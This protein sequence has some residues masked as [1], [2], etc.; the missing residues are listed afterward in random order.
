MW[1]VVSLIFLAVGMQ[2]LLQGQFPDPDD[3][4][5][6]VQVRDLLAG[7]GWF[8]LHQYRI[9]PPDGTLMHWSRLVDIPLALVILAL[10]PFVGAPAAETAAL[11]IVPLVTLGAILFV[12]GRL[13]WRL[14]DVD[15]AGISCL[16]MALFAPIVF[17][18]QPM[19]IDHHGWQIFTV[20]L[21]LWACS[22]RS[23]WKG[24]A[25]AGLAMAVGATISLEILPMVAA[26]G[27]ILALRWFRDHKDRWWLVGYMQALAL[28]LI[29]AFFAT[30]GIADLAQHCDVIAPAHLGFFAITAVCTGLIA[31]APAIPRLALFGAF[32]AAGAAGLAFFGLSSPTCLMTPFAALDP[33]VRDFWYINVLE[34]RPL[35]EQ[36]LAYA[37]PSFVQLCIGLFTA[38]VLAVRSRDWLR[39]WWIEYSLLLAASI[40]LSLFVWRSAAFA[41]VIAAIPIGWLATRLLKR[42]N[43]ARGL[44]AKLTALGAIVLALLPSSPVAVAE[45][46]M[47]ES[48][49][50]QTV[51]VE[52]SSCEIRNQALTLNSLPQGTIFAPLDIGPAI[53]VKSHHAVAATGHHRAEE[54]MRDV[55]LAFTSPEAE[56][57]QI[58]AAHES[59]Y[60]V[61]CTDLAEPR[62][63]TAANPQGLAAQ[64]VAGEAPDWLEPVEVGGPEEFRVW[65]VRE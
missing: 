20:V 61:I 53:L 40:L 9:D 7:Q 47:P 62:L 13:A 23:A 45:L 38:I 60:I 25:L 4:L 12:I 22:L 59:D 15:V 51:L 33:L 3:A 35:W 16:C 24:G 50:V 14:F 54:S 42:L 57:R 19:R 6:L 64:L 21:A 10:S 65:R 1:G 27:G 36:K 48:G 58:V 32:G 17:Q 8:D 49:N 11:I 37:L 28:G 2:R 44:A 39:Q 31:A 52:E 34:G 30:R 46:M 18:L 41:A 55:I 29:A 5:R 56:A 43:R 63:F 26:F